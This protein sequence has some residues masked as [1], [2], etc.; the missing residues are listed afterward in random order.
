MYMTQ[1]VDRFTYFR[2]SKEAKVR[3]FYGQEKTSTTY[4]LARMN[5]LLHGVKYSDFNIKNDD[6]LENT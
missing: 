4:N 2:V 1:H 6:T 5:M 3:M